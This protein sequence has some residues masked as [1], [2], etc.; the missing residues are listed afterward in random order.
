VV[1]VAGAIDREAVGPSLTVEVTATSDDG[2]QS[3]E[4]FTVDVNDVDE[5]PS[6]DPNDFD[7]QATSSAM[8]VMNAGVNG[9]Q[10][11]RGSSFNDT[12]MGGQAGDTIYGGAGH[13]TIYG[14]NPTTVNTQADADIIYGGSG[15]DTIFGNQD[16]D[17]IWG[18]SG[19]DILYGNGGKDTLTGG[20]GA[21]SFAFAA[22]G[23]TAVGRD[24]ITD[25]VVG[26]DEI[27]LSL[28][29]ANTNSGSPG[30]QAFLFVA[31]QTSSVV[32]NS[33]TWQQTVDG[34]GANITL[35]RADTDGNVANG[36]ELEI[37]LTGHQSLTAADFNL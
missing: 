22:P 23:D 10:T 16:N 33:V 35:I 20:L 18:G 12:L 8:I 28:I 19:D 2:S 32:S 5:F 17:Q 14:F 25:F 31:V 11:V 7:D 36:A 30:N 37:Q 34:G 15:N 1:T 4:T 24:V 27:D 29:D 3:T 13:D 9:S 21:D 26:I 6:S